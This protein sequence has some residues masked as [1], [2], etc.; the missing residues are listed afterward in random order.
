MKQLI[1]NA[2]DLG[3]CESTN[4]AIDEAFRHGVLTSASLMANGIAFDHAVEHVV[5]PN[6]GLG[7]GLHVCL[8]NARSLCPAE[9]VPLLVDERGRFRHGFVSLCRLTLTRRIS[10]MEQIER[11]IAAQFES[12]QGRDVPVDHLDSHRHVH[13]IPAIFD[14]VIRLAR[15]YQCPA[16][17][18]SHEPFPRLRALLRPSR[19]PLLFNNVSKKLVLSALA[20]I[21]RRKAPDLLRSNRVY[22]I[23]GSGRMD[24]D[25]VRDA[26]ASAGEGTSEI[27]VHPGGDDPVMDP[28]ASDLERRFLLSPNRRAEFLA[29][30]DPGTRKAI[31]RAGCRP[32][33][34]SDV[35]VSE[36]QDSLQASVG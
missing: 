8:T 35:T 1:I 13:M 22:G 10:V 27:I 19:L 18:I 14:V 36:A 3:I 11:E 5:R 25:G 2:D 7:I 23:L 20:A 30:V 17:R 28:E 31:H 26:V 33:G 29:L 32:V 15:R 34:C 21:D 6:P 24:G 4:R 9:E 12:L 16:I